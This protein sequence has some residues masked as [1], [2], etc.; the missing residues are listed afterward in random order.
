MTAQPDH[1][2]AAPAGRTLTI[3]GV[4]A[5]AFA[6][7]Q[8]MV[9]PALSTLQE[10][11]GT[12]ASG[13]T[14]TITAY[15][16]AAAVATPVVG[17]LG[18]MFGKRRMLIVALLA[19]TAGSVVSALGSSLGVVIAGRVLQGVGGGIFPL[20]FAI[21]RDEL[22]REKVAVGI[23]TISAVLSV[24]GTLG[25]VIGGLLLD[26]ATYHWIFWV[27][28]VLGV[29]GTIGAYVGVPE[30][31]VKIPGKVDLRGALVFAVG[32]VIPLL[33][34]SQANDWGWGSAR[35]IGMIVAGLAIL[36]GWVA[37]QARTA[38]P[39]AH[40]PTLRR[41][42]VLFTNVA[43]VLVGFGMFGSF[44]VLP[45]LLQSP[46]ATGYG[47]GLGATASG[48]VMVPGGLVAMLAA[49][50]SGRMSDR[51]GSHVPLSIG[52]V[53]AAV[54]LL[55]LAAF[56]G[57]IAVIVVGYAV[58]SIG[59]GLAFAAMPNLIVAAVSAERTGEATGF[60]TV[61]R[62]VGSS[63]GS[64]LVVTV[65]TASAVAGSQL[66]TDAG[67]SRAFALL[68]ATTL[69][70]GVLSAFIPRLVAR[71]TARSAAAPATAASGD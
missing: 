9:V 65:L 33:A 6:L 51:Y 47:F 35:V 31:P 49:P 24:G 57:S 70:A 54:G 34:I 61:M 10:E 42:A 53:I 69:V 38:E 71:S 5:L 29:L 30:S 20:C 55:A 21:A 41:P 1:A 48:L 7:A 15:L 58:G 13:A 56:H 22:P 63:V 45:Q 40:V 68:A 28:A 64:Q 23:A 39:I 11:L 46:E 43:T 52:G 3:L 60:N 25:L 66:P 44:V 8:T 14:W 17:R 12:D 50:L 16:L 4:C 27:G 62:S 59:I 32:I 2:P 26:H 18:D 67:F 36:A 37:L 19:F